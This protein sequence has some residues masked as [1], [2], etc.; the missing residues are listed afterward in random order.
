MYRWVEHTAEL[1]LELEAAS[2][3]ELLADALSALRELLEGVQPTP[4][5]RSAGAPHPLRRRTVRATARDRPALLAA[6]LEEL[7]FLSES[8]GFIPIEIDE[9]VLRAD[10]L[11]ATVAGRVGEPRPLVKAVTYHRLQFESV[12]GGYRGRVVFD[13]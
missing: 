12:D 6:W 7:L 3:Q 1:E 5:F 2:E 9:L 13:V 10:G 11:S 4:H 8:A